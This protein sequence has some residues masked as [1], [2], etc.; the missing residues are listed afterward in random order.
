MAAEAEVGEATA[1]E[2]EGAVAVEAEDSSAVLRA[3]AKEGDSSAVCL[4]VVTKVAEEGAAEAEGAAVTEP[5][6]RG[7][8][9]ERRKP[10]L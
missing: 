4:A 10:Q 5:R 8:A 9:M 1:E 2:E 3:A 7:R 6:H